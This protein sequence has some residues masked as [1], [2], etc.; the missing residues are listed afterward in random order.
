MSTPSCTASELSGLAAGVASVAYAWQAANTG[1][2][3]NIRD[4]QQ[5]LHQWRPGFTDRMTGDWLSVDCLDGLHST[6]T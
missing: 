4:A 5:W 6:G 3:A 1:P 2:A